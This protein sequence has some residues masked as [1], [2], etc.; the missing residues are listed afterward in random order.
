MHWVLAVETHV[1]GFVERTHTAPVDPKELQAFLIDERAELE[2]VEAYINGS[3]ERAARIY[4][5]Q[6]MLMGI[7]PLLALGFLAAFLISLFDAFDVQDEGDSHR[8]CLRRGRCC[9]RRRQC[10]R[11][12]GAG[13]TTSQSTRDAAPWPLC[14]RRVSA[15]R[16]RDL[17]GRDVLH[18]LDVAA[19]DRP[20][21]QELRVLRHRRF[22]R[23]Q[24]ARTRV[25]RSSA[26]RHRRRGRE[27]RG[28]RSR[29]AGAGGARTRARGGW[30]QRHLD[31]SYRVSPSR[32]RSPPC[33]VC[34]CPSIRWW[35]PRSSTATCSWARGT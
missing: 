32:R 6:G 34:T 9:G 22:R 8:L 2:Q 35:R 16:G 17:R 3:G 18:R 21:D 11:G 14:A 33:C 24:R 31:H 26:E 5:I 30:G 4:F 25:I 10:F 15:D 13:R 7:V 20:G 19:P 1:L 12:W 28:H 29:R 23:I 27:A